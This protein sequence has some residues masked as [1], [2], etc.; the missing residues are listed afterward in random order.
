MKTSRHLLQESSLTLERTSLKLM[1][2]WW[3]WVAVDVK[4]LKRCQ[5]MIWSRWP[6][7]W[8]ER[9]SV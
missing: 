6:W 1:P 9:V 7:Y 8:Q 4:E 5:F 2:R 3:H